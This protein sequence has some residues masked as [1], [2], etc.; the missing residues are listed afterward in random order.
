MN[1]LFF[2]FYCTILIYIYIFF[3]FL[4]HRS[5][6]QYTFVKPDI[7]KGCEAELADKLAKYGV[8]LRQYRQSLSEEEILPSKPR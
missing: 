4:F 1:N 8:T 7:E 5:I 6:Q 3:F 2:L